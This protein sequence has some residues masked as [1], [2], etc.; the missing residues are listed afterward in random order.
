[1]FVFGD[2]MLLQ[3]CPALRRVHPLDG[4]LPDRNIQRLRQ[5]NLAVLTP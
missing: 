5:L 1:M 3:L 4:N 2:G